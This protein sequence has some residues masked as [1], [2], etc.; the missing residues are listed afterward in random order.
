MNY[1]D[2]N[3]SGGGGN[4]NEAKQMNWRTVLR[5]EMNTINVFMC[6]VPWWE[7]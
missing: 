2:N 6:V 4:N 5:Y 7:F 3:A 1:G